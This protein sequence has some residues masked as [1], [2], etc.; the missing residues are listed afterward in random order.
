MYWLFTRLSRKI[1][2]DCITEQTKQTLLFFFFLR[3]CPNSIVTL[4]LADRQILC[5]ELQCVTESFLCPFLLLCPVMFGYSCSER[6]SSLSAL[7]L[8]S[9]ARSLSLSLCGSFFLGHWVSVI[10]CHPKPLPTFS[11]TLFLKTAIRWVPLLTSQ[12]TLCDKCPLRRCHT[13]TAVTTEL[14]ARQYS[15]HCVQVRLVAP[16]E[17]TRALS[18]AAEHG[19]N[20]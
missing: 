6:M 18:Q 16:C 11:T 7:S 8:A 20:R 3:L 5:C 12:L 10:S 13:L 9:L 1:A 17:I 19:R 2:K 4:H 14:M 15:R